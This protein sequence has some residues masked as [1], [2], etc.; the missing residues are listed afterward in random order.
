MGIL[1]IF[2]KTRR[3]IV[4]GRQEEATSATPPH[5]PSESTV[6][7]PYMQTKKAALPLAVRC[8]CTSGC[9]SITTVPGTSP[10]LKHGAVLDGC[11]PPWSV[12]V[13]KTECLP[14]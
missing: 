13:Q 7:I 4:A 12:L 10:S 6:F 14:P 9:M 5:M 11:R 3:L 2:N 8:C 1:R